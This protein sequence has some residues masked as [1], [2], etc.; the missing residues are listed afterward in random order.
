MD[1]QKE[2]E[3]QHFLNRRTYLSL[4]SA[5]EHAGFG[6]AQ[7]KLLAMAGALFFTTVQTVHLGSLILPSLTCEWRLTKWQVLLLLGTGSLAMTIGAFVGN[8]SCHAFGRRK[9]VVGG[10][11]FMLLFGFASVVQSNFYWYLTLR[12]FS[13]TFFQFVGSNAICAILEVCP[14]EKRLAVTTVLTV[15]GQ[16]GATCSVFIA[17]NAL[18]S[19]GWRK[20]T[21][22]LYI[23]CFIPLFCFLFYLE[24]SFRHLEKTG[25][26]VEGYLVMS[27]MFKENNKEDLSHLISWKMDYKRDYFKDLLSPES[28]TTTTLLLAVLTIKNIV[29]TTL[30][31]AIPYI[32]H[33]SRYSFLIPKVHR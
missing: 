15:A 6:K 17:M 16:L 22:I 12:A 14:K 18:H 11:L 26:S 5:I 2:K 24:D 30:H 3:T 8:F 19:M 25:R 21:C 29:V 9:N 31:T 33:V 20:L 1:L 27:K 28:E 13:F 23:P 32:L 4:E 7:Y 10:M